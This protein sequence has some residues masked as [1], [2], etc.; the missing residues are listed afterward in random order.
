MEKSHIHPGWMENMIN[1]F[2]QQVAAL[3]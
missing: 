1:P 3:A 2:R